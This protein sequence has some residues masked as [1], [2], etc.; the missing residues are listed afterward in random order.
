MSLFQCIQ[1]FFTTK[2]VSSDSEHYIIIGCV[3]DIEHWTSVYL[4]ELPNKLHVTIT[5]IDQSKNLINVDYYYTDNY[6]DSKKFSNLTDI[7]SEYVDKFMASKYKVGF[8]EIDR[9]A[10]S[11]EIRNY[12]YDSFKD[13]DESYTTRY[14][15]KK[16]EPNSV[17]EWLEV[18]LEKLKEIKNKLQNEKE[19]SLRKGL[20]QR[21]F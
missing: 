19:K 9:K 18:E 6:T 15:C 20:S 11:Q 21:K 1:K 5:K 2:V 8:I 10:G 4:R 12:K 7:S 16:L 13:E 3:I 17:N 14:I